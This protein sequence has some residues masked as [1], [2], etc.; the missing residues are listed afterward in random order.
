[1][2]TIKLPITFDKGRMSIVEEFTRPFYSQVI[3]VACRI[4]KGE[5]PLELTY[6]VKDSSFIEFRESELRYTMGKFW[7]EL[8]LTTVRQGPPNNSGAINLIV[9][10]VHES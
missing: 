7:P 8:Q 3:A 2:D 5:L 4:E 1:M 9:D 6:G 10:F